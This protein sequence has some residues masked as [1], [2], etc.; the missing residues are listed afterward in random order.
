[1]KHVTFGE[2]ALFV[3]D[4]AADTLME[5]ARVLSRT[6]GADSVTLRAI[7][8]DGNTVEAAFLLNSGSSLMVE[9]T[10]SEVIA[11]ENDEAVD[12]MQGRIDD[13]MW[14]AGAH[15]EDVAPPTDALAD[16]EGE[17]RQTLP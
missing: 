11:P 6:S 5:Y 13:I 12:Y 10:N 4:T 1:M 3:G 2:K 14:L 17:G 16:D 15:F 9:S 8:A 7:S